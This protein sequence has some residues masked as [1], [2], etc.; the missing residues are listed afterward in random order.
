[1]ES[2]GGFAVDGALEA[3]ARD[4]LAPRLVVWIRR[5]F[6]TLGDQIR[7]VHVVS[8]TAQKF[9]RAIA[10][11]KRRQARDKR[12]YLLR[13]DTAEIIQEAPIEIVALDAV[14][15]DQHQHVCREQGKK[16]LV[17]DT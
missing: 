4:A 16:Q 17:L 3:I 9:P 10:F 6:D 12:R 15:R 11:V 2:S 5:V 1:R 8:G 7:P 14:H 13:L